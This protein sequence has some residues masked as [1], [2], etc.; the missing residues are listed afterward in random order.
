LYLKDREA[1]GVKS[2][3]AFYFPNDLDAGTQTTNHIVIDLAGFSNGLEAFKKQV[4]AVAVTQSHVFTIGEFPNKLFATASVGNIHETIAV[5]HDSFALLFSALFSGHA[6]NRG[7]SHKRVQTKW[8]GI[9]QRL[10][11]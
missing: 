8:D 6:S 11:I 7:R 2:E 10:L 1:E 3:L 4:R 9:K 5:F